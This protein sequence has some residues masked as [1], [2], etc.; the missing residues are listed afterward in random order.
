MVGGYFQELNQANKV[1]F[2]EPEY[3]LVLHIICKL[4]FVSFVKN[5]FGFKKYNFIEQGSKFTDFGQKLV[6]VIEN[7][8]VDDEKKESIKSKEG[9]VGEGEEEAL[10]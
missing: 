9:N 10:K 4:C 8:Q 1:D 7:K 6:K 5:W 3:V 2:D